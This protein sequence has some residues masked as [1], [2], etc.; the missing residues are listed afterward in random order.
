[1]TLIMGMHIFLVVVWAFI[2]GAYAFID[3]YWWQTALSGIITIC[4]IFTLAIDIMS[5]AA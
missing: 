5:L 1:M 4:W 3:D 2:T